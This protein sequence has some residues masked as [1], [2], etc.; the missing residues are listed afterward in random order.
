MLVGVHPIT[1]S[2]WERGFATPTQ[3]QSD[4]LQICSLASYDTSVTTVVRDIVEQF[5]R[6]APLAFSHLLS[7]GLIR[8]EFDRVPD[9]DKNALLGELKAAKLPS[10]VTLKVE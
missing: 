10:T 9:A 3:W 4:A 2:K 7:A 5:P 8:V 6:F 1:V